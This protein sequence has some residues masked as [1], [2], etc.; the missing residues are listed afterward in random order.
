MGRL[1]IGPVTLACRACPLRSLKALC[2]PSDE[3][4]KSIQDRKRGEIALDRGQVLYEQDSA[5][6]GLYT[7]LEGVLMRYRTLDDG[8]RQIVNF[9]FPGDLIG[10][11]GALDGACGHSV[12]AVLPARVCVFDRSDFP[13]LIAEH[14]RLGYDLV[15]I[16]AHEECALEQHM[17]S[18]GK[19]NARERVAALAIWLLR[20]AHDTAITD[21][22]NRL[23]VPITQ[24]Q[25]ADMAGL[26]PVHANRTLQSL[27]RDGLVDWKPNEL[28]VPDFEKT[29]EFAREVP[30]GVRKTPFI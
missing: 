13:G 14:P 2:P 16:A 18:L 10:L 19:R 8:R 5:T 24:V 1:P 6:A 3:Q 4:T 9:M 27:R 17:V 20:R 29:S 15:W 11:Q 26:S 7:V 25:I 12:E 22:K 21:A 30:G 23:A 28:L